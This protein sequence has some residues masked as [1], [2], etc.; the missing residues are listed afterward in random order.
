MTRGDEV[1]TPSQQE[2]KVQ[3]Q[4]PP[5]RLAA[6]GFRSESTLTPLTLKP[7]FFY[8]IKPAYTCTGE[9]NLLSL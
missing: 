6:G 2:G 8:V 3:R 4:P 9:L 7:L 1:S 5:I